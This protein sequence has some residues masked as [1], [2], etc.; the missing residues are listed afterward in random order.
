MAF[1]DVGQGDAALIR[2]AEGAAAIVDAGPPEAGARLAAIFRAARLTRV[3]LLVASH[4]HADHIGGFLELLPALEVGTAL[5]P[6]YVHGTST[7]ERYLQ[8][9]REARPRTR[10]ARSGERYPLG[11]RAVFQVL[12]PGRRLLEGTASDANNNSVVAR[13]QFGAVRFLFTGDLE[14][15]GRARMLA[16]HPGDALRA[17]VLK[18]AHH[19][20]RNGTD[21]RL[22]RTVRPR[23][24][25]LSL[26][27]NN[28]YG[29]PHR[30]TLAALRAAGLPA[31]RVLRTDRHGD[32]VFSTDGTTL[33]LV[34]P[35]P[36]SP[37]RQRAPAGA[38]PSPALH[39]PAAKA[40]PAPRQRRNP[41]PRPRRL[42]DNR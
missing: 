38:A 42:E 27:K 37:P 25:V 7:Q 13:L 18:V 36:G 24:A 26:G 19:G 23:Y 41:S 34:L 31:A 40:V 12:A 22:L 8:L 29:H 35:A 20:S 33:R 32:V 15:A 30:E 17:E 21:T 1:L 11:P 39:T 10:R 5:D 28:E 9:L 6:G 16:E 3:E 2:T 4:P 14:E